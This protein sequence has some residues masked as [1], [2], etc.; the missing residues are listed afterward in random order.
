MYRI[1]EEQ[2]E[3]NILIN[4]LLFQ[5]LSYKIIM[6]IAHLPVTHVESNTKIYGKGGQK[7]EVMQE[8]M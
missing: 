2:I 3:E 8:I 6:S 1:D 5:K 7:L 4:Y